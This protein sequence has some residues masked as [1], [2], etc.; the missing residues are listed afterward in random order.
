MIELIE[1]FKFIKEKEKNSSVPML[2]VCETERGYENYWLKYVRQTSEFDCLVYELVC[3]RLARLVGLRVPDVALATVVENTFSPG[4]LIQN[5]DLQPGTVTFASKD[6]R[7]PHD[8]VDKFTQIADRTAFKQ[9]A[10]PLDFIRT[11]LFDLHVDNRDRTEENFNMLLTKTRPQ[12]LYVIDHFDCFGGVGL[13]GRFTANLPFNLHETI[14]RSAICQQAIA[15]LDVTH[16]NNLIAHYQYL[17]SSESIALLVDEVFATV[18][19][20]WTLSADLAN[21]IKGAL[22]N[23][24]RLADITTQL[25][26]FIT[27]CKRPSA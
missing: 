22:T 10:D 23:S 12:E 17:C 26:D 11:A 27:R 8:M 2:F 16:I 21:R 14:L 6:V 25:G 1:T 13:Q 20:T 3:Q 9:Y 15:F 4:E 18:P 24:A 7:V 5:W 19:T